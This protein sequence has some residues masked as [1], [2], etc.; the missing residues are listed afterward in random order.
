MREAVKLVKMLGNKWMDFR[1]RDRQQDNEI[2]NRLE[3]W[4]MDQRDRQQDDE[5]DNRMMGQIIG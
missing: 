4:S 1:Q 3:R 5:I 2:D